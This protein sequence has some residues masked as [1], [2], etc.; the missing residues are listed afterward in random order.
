VTFWD[1][2]GPAAKMR[3]KPSPFCVLHH[4]GCK[5]IRSARK[6]RFKL[7]Y[8]GGEPRWRVRGVVMAD[9]QKRTATYSSA[10][11]PILRLPGDVG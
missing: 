2:I 4:R 7:T 11:N 8:G 6:T 9:K 1:E 10:P 3:I 5:A